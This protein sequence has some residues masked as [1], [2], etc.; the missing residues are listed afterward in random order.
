MTDEAKSPLRRRMIEDMSIRK[1]A[2][3]TQND[4]VQRVKNFAAFL[5]RSPDTASFEDVRRYQLHL[6]AAPAYPPSTRPFRRCGSF[7]DAC[8]ECCAN[9]IQ[10]PRSQSVTAADR[11]ASLCPIGDGE[12]NSPIVCCAVA[13]RGRHVAHRGRYRRRLAAAAAPAAALTS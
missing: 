1:F 4:Y 8:F 6:A 2:S 12:Q 3:K 13:E 10:L 5:G 9:G 7:S 11:A